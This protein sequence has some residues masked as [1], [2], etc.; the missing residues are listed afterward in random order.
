MVMLLYSRR[1]TRPVAG[2]RVIRS[3]QIW[4]ICVTAAPKLGREEPRISAICPQI[5]SDP[6]ARR[7]HDE[8]AG[9]SHQSRSRYSGGHET[10]EQHSEQQYQCGF[11][12]IWVIAPMNSPAGRGCP[13]CLAGSRRLCG[14]L[15]LG[16]PAG[17][18]HPRTVGRVAPG[19]SLDDG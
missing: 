16:R 9:G 18:R 3:V 12:D 17:Y 14:E 15:K 6:R 7:A 19:G 8:L 13:A 2:W 10:G 1:S 11:P 5:T 4:P